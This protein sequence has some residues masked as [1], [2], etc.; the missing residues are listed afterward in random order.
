MSRPNKYNAIKKDWYD[1]TK[2]SKRAKE[3]QLM[4]KAGV[5][6]KLREQFW[7]VLL[8][9]FQHKG[10]TYR[11][12]KYVADFVYERD[13]QTIVEDVKSDF[14]RKL[15]VYVMKKKL[16]LAQNPNLIFLES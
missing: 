13:W 14:T 4:E 1:S 3:L 9:T 11:G 16:L 10:T 15:P 7:F 12:I 5:I 6:Q 2:E 8:P